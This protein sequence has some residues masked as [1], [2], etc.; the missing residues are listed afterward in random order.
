MG[1]ELLVVVVVHI[2]EMTVWCCC[3]MIDRCGQDIMFLC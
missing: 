1:E 2:Y 3:R